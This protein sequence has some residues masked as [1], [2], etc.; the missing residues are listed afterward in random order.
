MGTVCSSIFLSSWNGTSFPSIPSNA[1][2]L[3][4]ISAGVCC[5][6]LSGT[7]CQRTHCISITKSLFHLSSSANRLTI[8]HLMTPAV[9]PM[10]ISSMRSM[11]PNHEPT[12]LTNSPLLHNHFPEN[13][14]GTLHCSCLI[15]S[16]GVRPSPPGEH[17]EMNSADHLIH[18]VAIGASSLMWCFMFCSA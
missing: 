2:P 18:H 3:S 14:S 1:S 17:L 13:T 11:V 7:G 8:L 5:P 9:V 15:R 10:T 12:F 16:Y 4:L 6:G